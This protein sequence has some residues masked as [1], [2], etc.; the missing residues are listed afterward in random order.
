VRAR[1][2]FAKDALRHDHAPQAE[3]LFVIDERGRVFERF[4]DMP[5][6]EW[7]E[8]PLPQARAKSNRR[9]RVERR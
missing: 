4:S 2:L 9:K 7:T 1:Q 8:V 3:H 6:G 5:P